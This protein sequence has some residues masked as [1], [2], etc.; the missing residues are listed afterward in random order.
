MA[1]IDI[2]KPNDYTQRHQR[3]ENFRGVK[4][5]NDKKTEKLN[6]IAQR[7][8]RHERDES[9]QGYFKNRKYLS[10]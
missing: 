9:Y 6:D 4:E 1:K 7:H 3:H 8:Q 2:K 5:R 10:Q